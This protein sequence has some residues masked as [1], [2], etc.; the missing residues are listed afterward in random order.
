MMDC[1]ALLGRGALS[2]EGGSCRGVALPRAKASRTCAF[3][4]VRR[5]FSR[6]SARTPKPLLKCSVVTLCSW[7]SKA[8]TGVDQARA[9]LERTYGWLSGRVGAGW[10]VG[11]AFSIAD[12]SAAPALFYSD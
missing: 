3:I 7:R 11:D 4:A 10:A 9:V 2:R 6:A 1:A 12:G 5:E 8:S